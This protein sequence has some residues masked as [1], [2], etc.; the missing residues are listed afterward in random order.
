M[1]GRVKVKDLSKNIENRFFASYF[2]W[3]ILP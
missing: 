3:N 1:E 2:V